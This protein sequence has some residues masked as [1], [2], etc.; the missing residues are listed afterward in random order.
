MGVC[1]QPKIAKKKTFFREGTMNEEKINNNSYRNMKSKV[2]LDFTIEN[3]ETNHKYQIEA[4]LLDSQFTDVFSTETVNSHN[5]II[6]FNSCYIC[7]YYFEK[8]QNLQISLIKDYQK[9]GSIQLPL[10]QIVGARG[11]TF[12]QK[13]GRN[14]FVIISAEGIRDDNAYLEFNF[15]TQCISYFDFSKDS[16][17]ISYLITSYGKKIYSSESINENGTFNQIKIP[18]Y[19]LSPI[20]TI[21]FYNSVNKSLKAAYDNEISLLYNKV[22]MGKLRI[23]IPLSKTKSLY[24]YDNSEYNPNYSFYD[25]ISAGIKIKNL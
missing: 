8:R 20:Y 11:S 15:T 25:F 3:I 1:E 17:R 19:L 12:K 14:S 24:I 7:D 4:K 6:I 2:K 21:K 22:Y 9:E 18:G 13:I 16:D 5:N 23:T 10:G